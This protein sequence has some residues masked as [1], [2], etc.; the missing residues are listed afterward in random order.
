MVTARTRGGAGLGAGSDRR[1]EVGA[2]GE[3][4]DL[5]GRKGRRSG[6]KGGFGEKGRGVWS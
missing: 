6:K 1:R 3:E 5:E 4:T 2:V